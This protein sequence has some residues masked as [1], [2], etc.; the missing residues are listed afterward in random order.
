MAGKL[1]GEV[2]WQAEL[3]QLGWPGTGDRFLGHE[4]R[5]EVGAG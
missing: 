3:G 1:R 4:K 5:I 2:R